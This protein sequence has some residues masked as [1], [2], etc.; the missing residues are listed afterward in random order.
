L[1]YL[2]ILNYT[3]PNLTLL[4]SNESFPLIENLIEEEIEIKEEKE[5]INYQEEIEKIIEYWN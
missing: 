2:T 5:N 4:N 1:E 3:L